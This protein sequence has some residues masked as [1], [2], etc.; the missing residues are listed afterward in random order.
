MAANNAANLAIPVTVSDGGTGNTSFTAYSVVCAGTTAT[1]DFQNVSGVGTSGQVLT[2]NGAAALPTWQ[3]PAAGGSGSLIYIS[4]S[5]PSVASAASFTSGI[6]SSYPNYKVVGRNIVADTNATSL[7]AEISDDGGSTW[8]SSS[9]VMVGIYGNSGGLNKSTSTSSILLS[10]SSGYYTSGVYGTFDLMIYNVGTSLQTGFTGN[11]GYPWTGDS[12]GQAT[13]TF[14]GT[15][16]SSITMNA[17]RFRMSSGNI[18]GT[19]ILYG[20]KNS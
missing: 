14:G 5:T 19:F 10:E 1:G 17:I 18:S 3:T 9:Y 6:G 13:F 12:G 20:I 2:S 11:A 16:S 15:Y 7:I 4:T 8:K